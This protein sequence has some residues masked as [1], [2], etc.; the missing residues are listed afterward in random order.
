MSKAKF[1]TDPINKQDLARF[2]GQPAAPVVDFIDR[3]VIP[4]QEL[5][6]FGISIDNTVFLSIGGGLGSFIWIDNLVIRGARRAHVM[7]IGMEKKPYGRYRRLCHQ[8]QIP[9]F[10]RLRSDSGSTPDNIWGWPGYAVREILSDLMRLRWWSALKTSARI[11]CEPI[12]TD[13]YTPRSGRVYASIDREAGRI[14]WDDINVWGRVHAIRKLDNGYF[15]VFYTHRGEHEFEERCAVAHYVHLAMGYPAVR[16][17][18]ELQKYRS[19]TGNLS[20]AVNAYEAHEHIYQALAAYGGLVAVRG[21]GIV[22]SRIIQRLC[23]VR[24]E[25]PKVRIIHILRK[26]I[27]SGSRFRSATRPVNFHWE[28]QPFNFPKSA[29][30]GRYRDILDM[31]GDETRADLIDSWGGTTTADR[32]AWRDIIDKGK[33][34]GWYSIFFGTVQDMQAVNDERVIIHLDVEGQNMAE[35]TLDY[36]I[37]ATGLDADWRKNPLMKDLIE[38]YHLPL[39]VKDRLEVSRDFEVCAMRMPRARMYATGAITLGTTFAPVDSFLGLQYAAQASVENM[40]ANDA[41][42]LQELGPFKSV[43]QW[44]RWLM[45]AQP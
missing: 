24:E 7:S 31:A 3:P 13:V 28:I 40:I 35:L 23:E 20:R 32:R 22:A 11:F 10:E 15:A 1:L 30:G 21:R 41:P 33:R 43:K 12:M 16:V 4:Y 8:S 39:N 5:L 2:P 42:C 17:L 6:D 34:E 38:T 29:W 9:D 36:M 26:P 14:G 25:Q 18:P 37:D 27:T 45:G 19:Q 44:S